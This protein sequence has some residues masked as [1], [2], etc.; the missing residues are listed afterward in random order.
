M[1][2]DSRARF[3]ASAEHYD[4]YRPSYPPELIDW[5]V[6]TTGIRVPARVADIGCGTGIATRLLAARGFDTVG[7]EPSEEMLAVAREAG[8]RARYV[9]GEA[10]ATTLP[11]GSVDLVTAAQCFHWFT[12]TPTLLELRRV[13][14]PGGWCC[15]FWNL[16]APVP[17]MDGYYDLIRT[18]SSEFEVLERQELAPDALRVAK[19]VE[20]RREAQFANRQTLDHAGLLGRA[21]SSSCVKLG[22]KDKAGFERALSEL[23]SRHEVGGTIELQYRTVALCWTIGNP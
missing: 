10:A 16:R 4:Q 1:M 11:D 17:F 14:R 22:V 23:F 5:I 21:Y 19:G 18:H 13:L 15:A 9:R 20:S 12:I 8:G 6:A 7:V 3:A 2:I